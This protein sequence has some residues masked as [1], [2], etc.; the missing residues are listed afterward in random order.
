MPAEAW[1]TAVIVVLTIAALIT[2]KI[3]APFAIMGAVIALLT[4]KVIDQDQAFIG[5][6][7]PAPITVA[8]LYV[9]VA[10][11]EKT[12]AMERVT[13]KVL[14]SGRSKRGD[15]MAIAR[16]AGPTAL[17]SSFLNNTPIVAMVAPSVIAWCKRSGRSPAR[18]LMPVSFAAILGGLMTLI[19]TST[20][21]VVSGLLK[22]AGEPEIS[23]F[24]ISKVGVPVAVGGLVL[25]VL[26]APRLL[27]KRVA[28]S[29]E[30]SADGREFSVEMQ[31]S[32]N[33]IAGRS[34][35][36]AGLR[37]LE[38]V[39]LAEI[40]RGGVRR[41]AVAP[42]EILEQGDRLLFVGNVDS[43]MDLQRIP[44]LVSAEQP[45][46]P[47]AS[48]QRLRRFYEVVVAEGSDLANSTL[49]EA[50]FRANFNAAVVAIHRRGERL[51]GKL[52]SIRVQAGDV[53]LVL[54]GDDFKRRFRNSREFLVVAPLG[55]GAPPVR[56]KAPIVGIVTLA[57]FVVVTAGWMDIMVAA[58]LAAA[59]LVLTRVL[60]PMEARTSID[61]N[62]L[63]VIAASF[64]IGEAISTSGLAEEIARN[65]IGTFDSFG[66]I[67]LLVAVLIA[68]SLFTEVITNNAAAV[69][70]FPLALSV[71]AQAGLDPRPFAIAI[72]VGASASFLSPIGYQTNTIVYGMGGYRFTDFIR[73]GLPLHLLVI[74]VASIVIPIAWPLN[75]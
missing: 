21:L 38:G 9:L 23:M 49:K 5:F 65:F 22:T 15:S 43:V 16:I 46:L 44:G 18:Y 52:G 31:V 26:T 12:G 29:E 28:P 13:A 54:A 66:N 42:D 56:E 55:G 37:N 24:E 72:A 68:T 41:T 74:T 36:E 47:T 48:E 35:L 53:L 51:P 32:G 58:L 60:T 45:H 40:N 4:L 25:L 50:G 17:A 20:N 71:A 59:I 39:F 62:V 8:A 70:M 64:G 6:S 75:P 67:G 11:V 14:G 63:I 57:L 2:E 69:L 19:G 61:I 10:A 73:V 3:S 7:N 1:I 33:E 30:L 34:I 27:P